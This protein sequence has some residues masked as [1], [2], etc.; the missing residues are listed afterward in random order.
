MDSDSKG[1]RGILLQYLNGIWKAIDP[2]YVSANWYLSRVQF[3]SADEGWALGNDES[4]SRGILLHYLK[5][6][7]T[8]VRFPLT[9]EW[10]FSGIHFTSPG[11][12]WIVGVDHATHR[13]G[14]FKI[15]PNFHLP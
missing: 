9:L 4:N 12:G 7:W 1:H 13:G 6:S 3:T 15:R 5:G 8:V 14:L 10:E 11:E 2:P